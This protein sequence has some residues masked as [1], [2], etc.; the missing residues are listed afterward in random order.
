[1]SATGDV[2]LLFL[3]RPLFFLGAVTGG[4]GAAGSGAAG[5]DGNA[6]SCVVAAVG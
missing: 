4:S 1:M 2:L 5:S 6:E 3:G